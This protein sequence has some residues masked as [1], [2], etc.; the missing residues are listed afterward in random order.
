[1]AFSPTANRRFPFLTLIGFGLIALGVLRVALIVMHEPVLGYGDHSPLLP[2]RAIGFGYLALF[3]SLAIAVAITLRA[4]PVA[5]LA[6]GALFFL[7]FADPV[8]TLWFNTLEAEPIAL[9]GAYGAI[10]MS[11]LILINAGARRWPWW[12]LGAA[13]IALGFAGVQF[14]CLPPLLVAL[15]APALALRSRRRTWVILCVAVVVALT[16]LLLASLGI[17]QSDPADRLTAYAGAPLAPAPE[18]EPGTLGDPRTFFR[19]VSKLLPAT[20]AIVPGYLRISAEGPVR[21]VSDLPPSHMSLVAL[22]ARIP[23]IVYATLVM[24]LLISFP[25]AVGWLAWTARKRPP[26]QLIMPLVFAML[27]AIVGYSLM[28]SALGE[29]IAGVERRHWLGSIATL[30]AL[31]LVPFIA[32]YAWNDFFR[33]RVALVAALGVVLLAGCWTAWT[34]SRGLAIGVTEK[35]AEG[36]NRS[37]QVSGWALD[38]WGVRRVYATVGGGYPA[39]GSRGIARHDLEA[40]Y[41]GY[42]DAANGGFQI[43]IPAGKWRENEILRISV[44]NPAGGVT[45]IDRRPVLLR[46]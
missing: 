30:A 1:M 43:G 22:L 24:A 6:H 17:A 41:P 12:V 40:I 2:W 4:H 18:A 39:E 31:A 26:A 28:T 16:Q 10:A 42:P 15:G 33:A 25:V 36:P 29:S 38:P 14:A 7:L 34:P 5:S 37:L 8:V 32:H 46:P 11:V 44:E 23:V 21:T 3:S 9:L 27:A 19:R 13:L 35:M 45:E 20:E